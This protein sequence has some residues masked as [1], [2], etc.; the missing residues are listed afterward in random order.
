M[1]PTGQPP[2]ASSIPAVNAD[3]RAV[4]WQRRG[5]G[6]ASS[7][8]ISLRRDQASREEGHGQ[9][10]DQSPH[11]ADSHRGLPLLA[12]IAVVAGLL[13]MAPPAFLLS[14]AGI[15]AIALS[16]GVSPRLARIYP[17]IL[18]AMLVIACAAVLSLR[19]AGLPSR[20]YAWLSMLALLA[21]AAAAD[22]LHATGTRMP[23]RAAAAAVAGIP[24][25]LR[26]I[27]VGLPPCMPPPGPPP[28]AAPGPAQAA[29][30]PKAPGPV[31]PVAVR[32]GI[33]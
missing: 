1:E 7:S 22:A 26:L 17:L 11:P 23:R 15:H 6:S 20:S 16:S 29:A 13:P 5:R 21:A 31:R 18:D 24:G 33:G 2:F 14:Y 9:M 27:G 30:R 12:L 25:G 8:T 32:R 3:S 4:P 10:I 19:G 28:P